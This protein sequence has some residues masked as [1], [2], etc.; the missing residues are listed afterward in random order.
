MTRH[1]KVSKLKVFSTVIA[2][3]VLIVL[4][5]NADKLNSSSKVVGYINPAFLGD[6]GKDVT[7]NMNNL[8]I[9]VDERDDTAV[10]QYIVQEGDTLETIA[11]E[12]GT[13]V[14]TLKKINAISSIKPGQKIIVT[15]EE[16][17]IIYTVRETQNI[18]VFANKYGLNLSDLM[19]LNYI[20]DDTEMLQK[21][22]E[23]FINL[24][25]EKANAIP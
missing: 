15:D 16:D 2:L 1:Q 24:T 23:I 9:S 21:G 20:T 19:T 12:F 7:I 4:I 13:T 14:S 18:K 22:Q 3:V 8:S 6:S 5:V 10:V 25:E 17:G 11:S